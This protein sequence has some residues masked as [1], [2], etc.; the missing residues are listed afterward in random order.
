M[1]GGF[2]RGSITIEGLGDDRGEQLLIEFQNEYLVAL[3]GEE[4]LAIV[5]DL[6]C[7]ADAETGD[8][9]TT[10]VIRYGLRVAVLGMPAPLKL[11]TDEA[12]AVIG[13]RAFGYSQ[14]FTPL[15]GLYG[16]D[17]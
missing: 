17:A 13:P 7:I 11:K 16:G 4:V 1:E 10:E 14:P 12:L 9:I 8:P 2:A 15:P 3:R 5:P 6:I